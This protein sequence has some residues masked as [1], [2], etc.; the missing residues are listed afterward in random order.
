VSLEPGLENL[1]WTINPGN[2]GSGDAPVLSSSV[3]PLMQ[4]GAN[5]QANFDDNIPWALPETGSYH[6]NVYRGSS[7]QLN[8]VVTC[9]ELRRKD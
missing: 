8:N 2:C 5:G 1:G 6:V 3:F 4:L 9:A 7:T